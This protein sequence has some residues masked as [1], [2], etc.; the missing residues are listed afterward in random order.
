MRTGRLAIVSSGQT[1]SA[2]KRTK[3][4]IS[5][6]LARPAPSRFLTGGPDM[7]PRPPHVRRAPAQP[8]RSSGTPCPQTTHSDRPD[9]DERPPRLALRATPVLI[10]ASATADDTAGTRR[11]S[12]IAEI[13]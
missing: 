4:A 8:W 6:A 9:Y 13:G 1:S 10:A 7:A 5:S 11:G 2:A 3:Q 12:N